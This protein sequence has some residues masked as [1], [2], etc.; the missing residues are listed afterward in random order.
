MR[1]LVTAAS[2]HGG[3]TGIAEAIRDE[4]VNR[5]IDATAATPEDGAD[6][7]A[8]DGVVIGS[9]V[10]AGHWLEP[11][12][13]F[14]AENDIALAARPVWLFSSGPLGDPLKPTE[15]PRDAVAIGARI[16]AREHR[17]FAGRLDRSTLGLAERAILRLIRAK[18]A[19]ARPWD[20]IRSWA[21][22]IAGDLAAA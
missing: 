12:K 14:V 15:E 22:A 7:G 5:G 21:A 10:Y 1:V 16:G 9:A 17:V 4:L 3:T 13:R 8:Y 18:D 11:A 6:V 19:D 20:E 2:K